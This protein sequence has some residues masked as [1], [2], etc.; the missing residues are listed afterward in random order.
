MNVLGGEVGVKG[1]VQFGIGASADVGL[2]N[3]KFKVEISASAGLGVSLGVEVDVGGMVN[4]VC[5]NAKSAWNGTKDFFSS[6]F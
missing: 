3:G 5:S 2:R 6:L 1:G 4:T